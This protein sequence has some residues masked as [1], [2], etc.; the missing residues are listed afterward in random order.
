[1][2]AE[3]VVVVVVVRLFFTRV[4]FD[5]N[6]TDNLMALNIN[7]PKYFNRSNKNQLTNYLSRYYIQNSKITWHYFQCNNSQVIYTYEELVPRKRSTCVYN[8][9]DKKGNIWSASQGA[10]P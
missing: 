10:S 7:V 4:A 3:V 8:N 5:S 2:L 6:K 1:V 9:N